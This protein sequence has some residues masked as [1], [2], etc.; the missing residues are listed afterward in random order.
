MSFFWTFYPPNGS[1]W[2]AS[3]PV[4][5]AECIILLTRNVIFFLITLVWPLALSFTRDYFPLWSQTDSLRS[6]DSLLRDLVCVK[7]FRNFL[8]A[9]GRVQYLQCWIEIELFRDAL[10]QV[11]FVRVWM[12]GY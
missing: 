7:H 2:E 5:A 3:S 4:L 9:H 1:S 6:I 12:L 8:I 10:M 11:R